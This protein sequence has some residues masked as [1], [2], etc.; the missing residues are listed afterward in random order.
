M[1]DNVSLKS[2]DSLTTSG[3]YEIV[4]ETP[5]MDTE[6]QQQQQS[7]LQHKLTKNNDC[8]KSPTL[9]IANNGD[10]LDLKK[11]MTEVIKELDKKDK[12]GMLV[13]VN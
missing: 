4:S 6:P 5:P 8:S 2:S 13:F 1:D 11:D 10:F 7:Q 12:S 3:E 9:D